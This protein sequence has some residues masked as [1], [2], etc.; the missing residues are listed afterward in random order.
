MAT[1]SVPG[2]G[3][4]RWR[5]DPA[6]LLETVRDLAVPRLTGTGG[7]EDVE[8]RLRAA[9]EGLGYKTTELSFSLSTWPGRFGLTIAGLSLVAAGVG[10]PLVLRAG[11][12]GHAF[13]FLVGAIAVALLPLLTLDLATRRLPWGRVDTANLVFARPGP[14]PAWLVMAH[15]DSKSQWVPTLVRTLAMVACVVCL[16]LL[17]CMVGLRFLGDPFRLSAVAPVVGGAMAVAGAALA[18]SWTGNTSDGA[19]DN[20]T[21]L[22]T[23]LA[24]AEDAP[25]EVGFVV[26]DAEELGLAGA[27]RLA[28][29]LPPLQGVINVDGLDDTGSLRIAEGHGV[30][31]R[32]QAPR[33]AAALLA[34]AAARQVDMRR[35]PVPRSIL[36][37]H[38]P[39]AAAGIPALTL[40][41]GRLRSLLRVHGSAD[42]VDRLDGSGAA[43]AATVLA[44]ALQILVSGGEDTLRGTEPS[45]H[46]HSP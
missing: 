21:G 18:L 8:A 25:P 12:A 30:R 5:Y 20:A 43:E 46:S 42:T 6:A 29:R 22:A 28:G 36:V 1:D 3:A 7:A 14:P 11:A 16:L 4:A 10:T 38:E 19:L 40:M 9:F 24:V 37:D 32:G 41:R 39:V 27:R 44:G 17:L 15:R 26:T 34:A 35:R 23:I 33:L 31:Q 45:D 2:R 13:G